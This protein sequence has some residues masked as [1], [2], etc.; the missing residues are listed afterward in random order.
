MVVAFIT[1]L[2]NPLLGSPSWLP[3]L[4]GAWLLTFGA[5]MSLQ[6]QLPLPDIHR[7]RRLFPD[8]GAKVGALRLWWLGAAG[9]GC[10]RRGR[11]VNGTS[12]PRLA[13]RATNL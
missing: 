5:T 4:G 9:G 13:S 8:S 11:C 3:L 7:F 10:R 2:Q 1:L 6:A 12:F